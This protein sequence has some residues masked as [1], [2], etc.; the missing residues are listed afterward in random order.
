MTIPF[1][2]P[3]LGEDEAARL[4][5]VVASGYPNDGELTDEFAHRVAAIAGCAHGVGVSS[6]SAAL[7]CALVAC[8]VGT[9]DEVVVPDLTF[10]ATAN[11]V[12]LA[13]ATA[14]L[15]DVRP[16]DFTIDPAAFARAITPRTRGVVPVHV[17]GRGG[18][19]REVVEIARSAGLAVI[20]DACEALASTHDGLPLGSFGDVSAFSFAPT[21]IVTT[22]QGGV[23]AT[24]DAALARKLREL[25][26]QGR[27][28]RGTGGADEHPVYGFNFKLSNMHAAVGLAQLDRLD[29]RRSHIDALERW[30][31]E[32]LEGLDGVRLVDPGVR[33]HGESL[34]WID[35][36]S[37]ERDALASALRAGG[38]EPRELWYPL[39]TQPPYAAPDEPFPVA[40]SVSSR[41][42]WLPS[43]LSLTRDDVARVGELVRSFVHARGG[44]PVA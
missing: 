41:G 40:T 29:E 38:A 20:E 27:A 3:V 37:D 25:K 42:L 31:R 11:A 32:E 44:A 28:T 1:W 8:G 17:N 15:V 5:D 33:S 36:L 14:V 12:T 43:A 34:A 7:Y 19:I 4:R 22:G 18:S 10:I 30:Y 2:H 24:N 39:H 16:S 13:G 35:V 23:A 26:D 9:G 21:K 6:G